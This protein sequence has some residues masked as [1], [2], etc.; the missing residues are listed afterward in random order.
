MTPL[1][2][3]HGLMQAAPEDETRRLAFYAHLAEVEVF[4]LLDAEADGETIEPRLIE[5]EGQSYVLIFDR[6]DRLAEYANATANYIA[7]PAR[8]VAEMVGAN[9]LGLA[10]NLGVAPSSIL[11][12]PTAVGWLN[13]TLAAPVE[14]RSDGPQTVTPAR[15]SAALLEAL[16]RRLAR[17]AGLASHAFLADA[18]G[19]LL[20]GIVGANE[21]AET[22][23]AQAIGDAAVLS[24]HDAPVDVAFFNDAHPAVVRLERVGLRID[25]PKPEEP[26]TPAAPGSNPDTPPRLK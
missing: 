7:L 15:I 2:R 8:T 21:D 25:L 5:A 1:D 18:D 17:A 24:G 22:A 10:V 6:E 16:D 12:P 20:V 4:M 13:D 26:P 11:L 19:V 3:A 14:A 23:L 9:G